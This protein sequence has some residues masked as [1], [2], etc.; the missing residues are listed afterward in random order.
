MGS[1][2]WM[3]RQ[4]S[5]TQMRVLLMED[6]PFLGQ[7]VSSFLLN[8][9]FSVDVAA[10]TEEGLTKGQ[11]D[12]YDAIILELQLENRDGVSVVKELRRHGKDTPVLMLTPQDSAQDLVKCLDSGA[13]DCLVK[14]FDVAELE[15]RLRALIR[16]ANVKP[17]SVMQIGPAIIDTSAK[18]VTVNGIR[19]Q[20]TNKEYQL[21]V[22]LAE[23]RGIVVTR[24]RIYER[25]FD[26]IDNS[27]A[28][29]VD[30]YVSNIRRKMGHDLIK[31]LRGRG[32]MIE[33]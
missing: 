13:D 7:L 32:Y 25:L 22:F 18:T 31:T 24:T 11:K 5:D 14:P 29:L 10:N 19:T 9:G 6:E 8:A 26:E 23:N 21:L 16:R 27:L 20:L 1:Q 33:E 30:V 4:E 2:R 3:V 28:N 12:A 17:N 15:A